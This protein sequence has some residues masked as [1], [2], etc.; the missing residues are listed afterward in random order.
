MVYISPYGS[1][2]EATS[3]FSPTH[4]TATQNPGGTSLS[5][6]GSP[7]PV[8]AAKASKGGSNGEIVVDNDKSDVGIGSVFDEKAAGEF[9]P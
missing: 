1:S 4:A 7:G 5:P 2:T 3:T 9:F 6:M 8:C